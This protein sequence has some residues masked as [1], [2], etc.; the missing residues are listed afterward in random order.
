MVPLSRVF[1]SAALE[2][3][4]GYSRAA[5]VADGRILVAGTAPIMPGDADPP[6]DVY[7][8]AQRC[9]EIISKALHEAGAGLEHVV[10]TRIY[11]TDRA[12]LEEVGR[13]HAAA[14]DGVWPVSTVVVV[15][16]IDPRWR[17]EIEAEAIAP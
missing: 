14:F 2:R 9:F 7:A 10:R 15:Q 4:Y 17:V 6:P 12:D 16:L 1:S 11:I 3:K 5:V 8:Q 13:A